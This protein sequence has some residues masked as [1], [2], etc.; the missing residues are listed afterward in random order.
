[1]FITDAILIGLPKHIAQVIAGHRVKNVTLGYKA[2]YPEEAI[3]AHRTFLARRCA[4][5]P[6]EE[7]RAPTDQEWEE[8]VG[9]WQRRKVSIGA[10]ARAFATPCIHEHASVCCSVL[11]PDP[12]QRARFEEIRDS[13][14]PTS[15]EPNV[16][17]GEVRSRACTSLSPA[18]KARSLNSIGACPTGRTLACPAPAID[19]RHGRLHQTTADA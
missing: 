19:L 15:P 2:I 16:K 18:P 5:R 4:L 7:Y 14:A 3:Q 13:L 1:M 9:H 17:A 10:C 12:A 6:S 8:F 11:W